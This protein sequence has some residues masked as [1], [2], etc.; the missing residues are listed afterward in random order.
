MRRRAGSCS[1]LRACPRTATRASGPARKCRNKRAEQPIATANGRLTRPIC[2]S[3]ISRVRLKWLSL[4]RPICS[5]TISRVRLKWLSLDGFRQ[6]MR[7]LGY[8]E[9]RNAVIE[10]RDA[11]GKLERLPALAAELVALKVDVIMV[12]GTLAA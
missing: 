8:V 3:T 10:Y 5:S 4:T 2:S 6:G 11:E 1:R 7:D 12:G 9:G